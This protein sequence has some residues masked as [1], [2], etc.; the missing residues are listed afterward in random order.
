MTRRQALTA[1]ALTT[2][3]VAQNSLWTPKASAAGGKPAI[4]Y[5]PHQDDDAIG[6]AGSVLEHKAAGRPVYLVLVSNGLNGDLAKYMNEGA[7][8]LC[9]R[10]RNSSGG[11][12]RNSPDADASRR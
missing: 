11:S 1:A 5:S 8:H 9:G 4:F 7:C 3:A 2:A 6:L 10:S 12:S